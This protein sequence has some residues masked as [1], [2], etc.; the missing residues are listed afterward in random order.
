MAT[1]PFDSVHQQWIREMG[2]HFGTEDT[3]TRAPTGVF[4]G[5]PGKTVADPYFGG[6]GP[7]RTGCTRCGACMVGCRVGAVNSLTQELLVVCRTQW[8]AGPCPS[9]RCRR[10]PLGAADGSDGYRVTTERPGAAH[11]ARDRPTPQAG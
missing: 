5:E 4:F 8:R 7:D 9:M 11:Q 2:R 3:F 10:A 6:A 1:V